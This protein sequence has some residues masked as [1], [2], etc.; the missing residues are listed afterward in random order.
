MC[1]EYKYNRILPRSEFWQWY[2]WRLG[3]L[4]G[5]TEPWFCCTLLVL[6]SP[7]Y[8]MIFCRSTNVLKQRIIIICVR[9]VT[10]R[11]NYRHRHL[12]ERTIHIMSYG[13]LI[14]CIFCKLFLLKAFNSHQSQ[15]TTRLVIV[16]SDFTFF[17]C[18]HTFFLNWLIVCR[19]YLRA[20]M[21]G[22]NFDWN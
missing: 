4:V 21:Y 5:A 3:R 15:V 11:C 9:F 20:L 13:I 18:L 1:M 14:D 7:F 6:H 19:A 8:F 10:C 2:A 22:N 12:C 17:A 16:H